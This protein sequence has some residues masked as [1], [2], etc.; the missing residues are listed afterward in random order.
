MRDRRSTSASGL[1]GQLELEVGAGRSGEIASCSVAGRPSCGS[2]PSSVGVSRSA[3]PTVWR[4]VTCCA[5]TM[6][7]VLL[8]GSPNTPARRPAHQS[9]PDARSAASA[10]ALSSRAGPNCAARRRGRPRARLASDGGV[11]RGLRQLPG[12]VACAALRQVRLAR[13]PRSASRSCS[14]FC[15]C[16]RAGALS[17]HLGTIS[18]ALAP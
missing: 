8:H 1:A 6:S 15:S 10:T 3:R 9:W 14:K 4:S 13:A 7:K 12:T 16:V 2:A 18:S 17:N 11:A 5:R